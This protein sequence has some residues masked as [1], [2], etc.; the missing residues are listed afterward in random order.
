MILWL[1]L[2]IKFPG[3]KF[4]ESNSFNQ[5][6]IEFV[7]GGYWR[8]YIASLFTFFVVENT[9]ITI[10]HYFKANKPSIPKWLRSF[11]SNTVSAPFDA[12]LFATLAFTFVIP[13]SQILQ[14]ILGSIIYKL[15][16]SYFSIP[17]LYIIH[18]Q[19]INSENDNTE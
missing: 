12:I 1:E 13:Y 14:I 18:S 9:D 11:A 17:L 16:V 8:V 7:F 6:A 2:Y 10:Y 4:W 19:K 5:Q 3:T 15:F